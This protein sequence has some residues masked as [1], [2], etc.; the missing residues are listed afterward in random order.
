MTK[1]PNHFHAFGPFRLDVSE[2]RLSRGEQAIQLTPRQFELLWLFVQ[3]SGHILT[4]NELIEKLWPDTYVAEA[5]LT[6]SISRLR[7]LL[8]HDAESQYIETIPRQG[9][10]FI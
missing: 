4:K 2:R 6:R 7:E 8:A 9:Y 5:T 3:H 10:R 1:Q